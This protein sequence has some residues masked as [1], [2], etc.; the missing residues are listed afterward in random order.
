MIQTFNDVLGTKPAD[1]DFKEE[2]RQQRIAGCGKFVAIW[3]PEQKALYKY[4]NRC[5]ERDCFSCQKFR[6]GEMAVRLGGLIDFA[7]VVKLPDE[8]AAREITGG[9]DKAQYIR[10]PKKDGSVTLV[11]DIDEAIG[12]LLTEELAQQIAPL[13]NAPKGKKISGSLGTLPAPRKKERI[14]IHYDEIKVREIDI[15]F[16]GSNLDYKDIQDYVLERTRH[17]DPHTQHELQICMD[18]LEE[19][20]E[21]AVG[22]LLGD[23]AKIHFLTEK[24]LRVCMDEVHWQ[25]LTEGAEPDPF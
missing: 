8:I 16:S 21:A 3:L 1:I 24:T 7:Q 10:Y 19:V 9:L 5:K 12:D 25:K 23:C 14:G 4:R 20:T 18:R 15:D 13:V 22:E 17:M 2:R 6:E 11:V